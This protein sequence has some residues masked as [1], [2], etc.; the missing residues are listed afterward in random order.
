[1]RHQYFTLFIIL[2]S[3]LLVHWIIKSNGLLGRLLVS[4]VAWLIKAWYNGFYCIYLCKASI[5]KVLVMTVM[6]RLIIQSQVIVLTSVKHYMWLSLCK[7]EAVTVVWLILQVFWYVI[8]CH[9]VSGS[10]CFE[11]LW[12]LRVH[13]CSFWLLNPWKWRY[14]NSKSQEPHQQHSATSQKMGVLDC[15]YL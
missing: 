11:V 6:W 3:L 5:H 9:W 12:H 7:F 4:R 1:M 8:L 10:Q 15:L 2:T 14:N 13:G